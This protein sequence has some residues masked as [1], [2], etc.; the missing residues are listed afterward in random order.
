MKTLS[1]RHA[2]NPYAIAESIFR[3]PGGCVVWMCYDAATLT[4]TAYHLLGHPG[5][6]AI[7]D[8]KTY[9]PARRKKGGEWIERERY[10]DVKTRQA[11]HRDLSLEELAT[12][13]FDPELVQSS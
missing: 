4:P 13:L 1:K 8:P 5:N 6:A 10:V 11:N 9:P 2:A 12:I 7:G 3:L